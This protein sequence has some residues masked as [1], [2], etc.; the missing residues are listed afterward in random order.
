MLD[1]LN[2]PESRKLIAL[3]LVQGIQDAI[4]NDDIETAASKTQQL[5]EHVHS[6][7]Q[8][9]R[10]KQAKA[11]L[12]D[13]LSSDVLT[14]NSEEANQQLATW[15]AATG[16][17]AEAEVEGYRKR[18]AEHAKHKHENIQVRGVIAHCEALFEQARTLEG[19]DTP[20]N[21]QLVLDNYYQ[22]ALRIAEAAYAEIPNSPELDVL[23]RKA[24]TL[25]EQKE[26]AAAIYPSA[27]EDDK[28]TSALTELDKLPDEMQIPRFVLKEGSEPRRA[29]FSNMV[30]NE[31]AQAEI[32]EQARAWAERTA[33]RKIREARTALAD[34]TPQQAVDVLDMPSRMETL[35]GSE[36]LT[37]LNDVRQRAIVTLQSQQRAQ[38]LAV[39]A[40]QMADE[41]AVAAYEKYVQAKNLYEQTDV[42]RAQRKQIIAAMQTVLQGMVGQADRAF[43]QERDMEGVRRLHT[44]AQSLYA[45]KD[46]SLTDLLEQLAE[47]DRM[48]Q[49]YDEFVQTA[50]ALMVQVK[51]T[52]PKD[53]AAANEILSQLETYPEIVLEEIPD[54]YEV[55]QQVNRQ[56]AAD[57]RYS[58]LQPGLYTQSIEEARPVFEQVEQA[59]QDF[60]DDERFP[61]LRDR[62]NLHL[63]FLSA[64]QK[65]ASGQ[66]AEAL[67]GL[68]AVAGVEGHPDQQR[69]AELLRQHGG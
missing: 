6:W 62:L 38:K 61:S 44:Q 34:S 68:R 13:A 26:S 42:D 21:P 49:Q 15:A 11:W 57:T 18:V 65:L 40:V 31:T 27:I 2:T 50:T 14:F 5:Q 7:Q 45:D 29:V 64:Q 12:D 8:S 28:Y 46:S 67:E 9:K 33:K 66:T 20:P 35:L 37:H 23:Q 39:E 3:D 55:R 1:S 47:F 36:T 17:E 53:V 30:A 43:H 32:R 58:N 16:E 10:A 19:S 22:R 24:S 69:A 25:N 54:L 60:P 63:Y 48:T 56:I 59:V 41:D 51:E 52:L 4:E